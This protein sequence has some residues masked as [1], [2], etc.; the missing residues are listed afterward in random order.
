MTIHVLGF[1]SIGRLVAHT[2]RLQGSP[3]T[4][5]AR[6]ASLPQYSSAWQLHVESDLRGHHER[7]ISTNY[8][9][10][11]SES[12]AAMAAIDTLLVCT[13]AYDSA[14][15]IA[16]LA[17][18]LTSKSRIVLLNN[19]IGV[20]EQVRNALKSQK[21]QTAILEGIISHGVYRISFDTICHAGEG[22]LVIS[23][24]LADVEDTAALHTLSEL[25]KPLNASVLDYSMFTTKQLEKLLVNVVINPLTAIG[26]FRNGDT[27]KYPELIDNI[28][29][30]SFSIIA[31]AY[32]QS[33]ID[34][35]SVRK[36]LYFIIQKTAQNRSSMLQDITARNL[37]EIKYINGALQRLAER[38]GV[39]SPYNVIL[40]DLVEARGH[41]LSSAVAWQRLQSLV[42]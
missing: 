24:A 15:S 17:A 26:N 21:L 10:E 30:E 38:H 12:T 11:S 5:L 25:L 16:R 23:C 32:P 1:G 29:M 37:T 3:V 14:S 4:I 42:P 8:A 22:N 19:G 18:R 36:T 33:R 34:E 2:L 13:K 28:L 9:F 27:A 39:Q 35:P 6:N 40:T 41:G 20:K 7:Q 31:A